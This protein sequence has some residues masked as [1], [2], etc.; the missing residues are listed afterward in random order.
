MFLIS[1]LGSKK[2]SL[3][4]NSMTIHSYQFAAKSVLNITERFIVTGRK[5]WVTDLP[6]FYKAQSTDAFVLSWCWAT[7]WDTR[8]S[9]WDESV[10]PQLQCLHSQRAPERWLQDR[11]SHWTPHTPGANRHNYNVRCTN[12]TFFTA[13]KSLELQYIPCSHE[14]HE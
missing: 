12:T 4:M 6:G 10:V 7:P 1:G 8:S 9:L 2:Q 13:N 11:G 3:A 5:R 14:S